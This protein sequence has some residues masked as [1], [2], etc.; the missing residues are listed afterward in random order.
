LLLGWYALCLFGFVIA[1][2]AKRLKYKL[3]IGENI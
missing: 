3:Y 1:E 2:F